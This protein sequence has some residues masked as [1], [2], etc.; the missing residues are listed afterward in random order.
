MEVNRTKRKYVKK[1]GTIHQSTAILLADWA[2]DFIPVQVD[3]ESSSKLIAIRALMKRDNEQNFSTITAEGPIGGV[4]NLSPYGKL[5]IAD[6]EFS[7]NYS[8]SFDTSEDNAKSI[9]DAVVKTPVTII[10]FPPGNDI[11]VQTHSGYEYPGED[12]KSIAYLVRDLYRYRLDI[13]D[14]FNMLAENVISSHDQEY[15][16]E[17]VSDDETDTGIG[18]ASGQQDYPIEARPDGT[19]KVKRTFHVNGI[20]HYKGDLLSELPIPESKLTEQLLSRV[21]TIL[22]LG[23]NGKPNIDN[24]SVNSGLEETSNDDETSHNRTLDDGSDSEASLDEEV[25]VTGRNENLSEYEAI[26]QD[27]HTIRIDERKGGQIIGDVDLRFNRLG[28]GEIYVYIDPVTSG[29]KVTSPDQV[30]YAHGIS[31]FKF[32]GITFLINENDCNRV[33]NGCGSYVRKAITE[34]FAD[35]YSHDPIQKQ[36]GQD[37]LRGGSYSNQYGSYVD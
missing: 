25:D 2:V 5:T 10:H 34:L 22:P 29:V 8:I 31:R 28:S 35:V 14:L 26:M 33:V 30:N 23:A 27:K 11:G 37:T 16:L 32:H 18:D 12:R 13:S 1:L 21:G 6:L 4:I 20:P 19:F 15:L 9:L 7:G 17:I 36:T 24:E 3:V